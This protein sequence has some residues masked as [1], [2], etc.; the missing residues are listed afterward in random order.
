M[1]KL[2]LITYFITSLL[3]KHSIKKY[4]KLSLCSPAG[5]SYSCPWFFNETFDQY[6]QIVGLPKISGKVF[7]TRSDIYHI[8]YLGNMRTKIMEAIKKVFLQNLFRQ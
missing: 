3:K 6:S 8:L 7:L 2:T 4:Q 5:N 1:Y